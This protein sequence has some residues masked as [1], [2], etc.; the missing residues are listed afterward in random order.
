MFDWEFPLE[1]ERREGSMTFRMFCRVMDDEEPLEWL[2][3]DPAPQTAI[4][5]IIALAVDDK[6][7]GMVTAVRSDRVPATCC[8]VVFTLQFD[9]ERI[10]VVVI[11][12]FCVRVCHSHAYSFFQWPG[13]VRRRRC[14]GGVVPLSG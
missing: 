14:A 11:N 2:D 3:V 7:F 12:S 4:P 1:M 13:D 9:G 6:G 5:L 8:V 10:A